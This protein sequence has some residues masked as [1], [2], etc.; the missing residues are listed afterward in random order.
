MPS[1]KRNVSSLEDRESMKGSASDRTFS[2]VMST[3][4]GHGTWW[5]HVAL[6]DRAQQALRARAP[7]SRRGSRQALKMWGVLG[8]DATVAR[9]QEVCETLNPIVL[10]ACF[11]NWL[12]RTYLEVIAY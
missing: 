8:P 3:K 4:R 1:C 12:I 11:I 2:G 7:V 9:G 10:S 5:V 6:R